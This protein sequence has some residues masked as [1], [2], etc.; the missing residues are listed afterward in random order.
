M[1]PRSDAAASF[2]RTGSIIMFA[3]AFYFFQVKKKILTTLSVNTGLSICV[4]F[5]GCPHLPPHSFLPSALC[6]GGWGSV[7]AHPSSYPPPTKDY[8][9]P[10][11]SAL[12]T[13]LHTSGSLYFNENHLFTHISPPKCSPSVVPEAALPA[14]ER[15]SILDASPAVFSF[16]TLHTVLPHCLSSPLTSP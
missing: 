5:K 2:V 4:R 11:S 10:E 16:L 3:I 15:H 9:S 8:L 7:H 1:S 14:V 6:G 13:L 12:A